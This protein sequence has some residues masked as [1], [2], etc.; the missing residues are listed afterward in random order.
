MNELVSSIIDYTPEPDAEQEQSRKRLMAL[1]AVSSLAM[2][3]LGYF[4]IVRMIL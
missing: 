3:A 1:F 4:V 2:M